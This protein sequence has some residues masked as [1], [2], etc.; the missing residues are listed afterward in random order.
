LEG[1][2]GN[3]SNVLQKDQQE[4]TTMYY[5]TADLQD[6]SDFFIYLET[7]NSTCKLVTITYN[8]DVM[9]STQWEDK[10]KPADI[11]LPTK[12]NLELCIY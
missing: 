6:Q 11:S 9:S 3:H 10:K 8:N 4:A 5:I 1:R 2:Y 7:S 12:A